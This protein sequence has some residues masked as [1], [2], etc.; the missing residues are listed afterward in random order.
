MEKKLRDEIREF[1]K[2][3]L[4]EVSEEQKVLNK[5]DGMFAMKKMAESSGQN[6]LINDDFKQKSLD[7]ESKKLR[8]VSYLQGKYNEEINNHLN[9]L[10]EKLK[11]LYDTYGAKTW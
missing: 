3:E 1:L 10:E 11:E 6:H 5:F 4:S 7:F 9:T 2:N 8:Q